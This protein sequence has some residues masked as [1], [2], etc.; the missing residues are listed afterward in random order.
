[1]SSQPPDSGPN[2]PRVAAALNILSKVQNS[3]TKGSIYYS[4]PSHGSASSI[5]SGG[6]SFTIP[7]VCPLYRLS[8]RTPNKT[9]PSESLGPAASNTT[10]A[11]PP[12][13]QALPASSSLSGSPPAAHTMLPHRPRDLPIVCVFG[14]GTHAEGADAASMSPSTS[15]VPAST[16][17]I[18]PPKT[19]ALTPP[20]NT[21][22]AS[23]SLDGSAPAMTPCT[24]RD[25][26]VVHHSRAGQQHSV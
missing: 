19:Q 7:S 22:P 16:I 15:L 17:D 10:D 24:P 23:P 20:S 14:G 2:A 26:P 11:Y 1:M 21:L 5:A 13:T 6:K 9:A 12:K 25:L 3:C 4:S 18:H 8:S